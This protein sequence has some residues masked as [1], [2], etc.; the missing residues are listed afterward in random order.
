MKTIEMR[1]IAMRFNQCQFPILA[2]PY[3]QT[4][5]ESGRFILKRFDAMG[6]IAAGTII[7][8]APDRSSDLDIFVI[9]SKRE[10]QRIQRFFN[11]VRAEIF[12]NP[13][14]CVERYFAEE[15]GD[16]R[17]CT[18]HMLATGFVVLNAHP[19]VDELRAKSKQILNSAPN[20]TEAQ[21][22]QKRYAIADMYENATDMIG[23]N[24]HAAMMLMSDAV[25]QALQFRFLAANRW[26][27]RYKDLLNE[28]E[29]LDSSLAQL[30]RQFYGETSWQ[31]RFRVA[32][33]VMDG[34]IGVRGF[35]EWESVIE[36]V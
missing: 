2:Q 17:P 36:K 10:R 24:P 7:R 22:T 18:A 13:P 31:E 28:L 23:K 33:A 19:I 5:E 8:G 11:G 26:L 34:T 3:R 1:A 16:G 14:H 12:V 29:A 27:P 21:L 32:E 4:L 35:F 6:I 25:H 9:H 15:S 20:L 30:A